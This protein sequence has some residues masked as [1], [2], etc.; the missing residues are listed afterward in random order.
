MKTFLLV[1][2]DDSGRE[3]DLRS[4]VDSLDNGAQIFSLDSNVACLK[5]NLSMTELSNRLLQF[6]GSS[7]FFIVN[8]TSSEYGGRM[9]GKFWDYVKSGAI[10]SAAE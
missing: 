4:Y 5:S 10:Q 9:V 6:S 8:V 3:I 1:F 7:L 2:D